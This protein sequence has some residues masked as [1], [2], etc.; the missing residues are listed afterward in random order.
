[1][2]FI[3]VS[4][5]SSVASLIEDPSVPYLHEVAK[6]LDKIDIMGDN[7]RRL[8]SELLDRPLEEQLAMRHE[9]GPTMFT[10][11]LWSCA[12]PPTE[13]TVGQLIKALNAIYRND[14]AG[15][16]EKHIKVRIHVIH[17]INSL[18]YCS[19]CVHVHTDFTSL[20]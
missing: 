10:L 11:M 3:A 12:K 19:C 17:L 9:K 2:A 5:S 15:I 8:W 13:A 1:M 16:L 6:I 7:W 14:V 20:L 4:S 18:E